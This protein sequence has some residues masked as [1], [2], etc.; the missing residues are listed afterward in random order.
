MG[1]SLRLV[2]KKYLKEAEQTPKKRARRPASTGL[3]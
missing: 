1:A 3:F 2:H